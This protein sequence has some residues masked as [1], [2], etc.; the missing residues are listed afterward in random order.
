MILFSSNKAGSILLFEEAGL[1]L[2][3]L[4]GTSG[5]VPSALQDE[6]L[7]YAL[8]QLKHHLALQNAISD[9]PIKDNNISSGRES[10]NERL[11]SITLS[12]RAYPLVQMLEQVIAHQGYLQWNYA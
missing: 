7:T 8:A 4:M 3:K 11:Q 12:Q 1:A 6:Y 9:T 10:D 2:L 5:V